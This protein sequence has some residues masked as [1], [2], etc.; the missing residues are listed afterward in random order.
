MPKH[1]FNYSCLKV[2]VSREGYSFEGLYDDFQNY[3]Q[4]VKKNKAKFLVLLSTYKF[5]NKKPSETLSAAYKL[6]PIITSKNNIFEKNMYPILCAGPL[7][8]AC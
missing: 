5:K 8:D 6:F 3:L 2:V 4:L 1:L 7:K